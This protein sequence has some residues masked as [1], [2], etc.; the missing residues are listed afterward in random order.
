VKQGDRVEEGEAVCAV[1]AMK[2]EH[3]IKASVGGVVEEVHAFEGAQV[4]DGAVLVVI[5]A[6]EGESAAAT[7]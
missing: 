2:M 3:V 6:E 4:D 1:E 7:A 5:K